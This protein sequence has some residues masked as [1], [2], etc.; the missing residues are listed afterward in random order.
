MGRGA[1][2][3]LVVA[4]LFLAFG[5]LFGG[6]SMLLDPG[7][8]SL[9]MDVVLPQLPV[10]SFVLPGLFLLTVMGLLPIFLAYALVA[11]PSWRWAEGIERAS[12]HH[13]AWTGTLALGLV[14][15]AWLALQ[16][17]MIGFAWPIQYVTAANAV[18]IV[19]LAVLPAVR[20]RFVSTNG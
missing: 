13:P 18:A 5:G 10:S 6:V 4:L 12:R 19:V 16:A 9:G 1:L 8:G 20:Q 2:I 14:L 3:A 11:R 7:G 15:G 17:A